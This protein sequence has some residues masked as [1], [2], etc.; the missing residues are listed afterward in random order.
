MQ[1]SLKRRACGIPCLIWLL[2]LVGLVAGTGLRWAYLKRLDAQEVQHTYALAR[3]LS[4]TD[5]A[6]LQFGKPCQMLTNTCFVILNFIT[7]QPFETFRAAVD[8]LGYTEV[9]S[10]QTVGTGVL[11]IL[12]ALTAN[13]KTKY[14]DYH[15]LPT[16]PEW[17]WELDDGTG[18]NVQVYYYG[19]AD[20]PD[21]YAFNGRPIHGNIASV[22]YVTKRKWLLQL[23]DE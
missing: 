15:T 10:Q 16:A 12:P 11:Y 22:V 5:A 2:V 18:P 20:Q 23:F 21:N 17:Y 6:A 3:S 19:I 14:D 8:Q 13:G 7:D 4:Y 1:Q 9:R